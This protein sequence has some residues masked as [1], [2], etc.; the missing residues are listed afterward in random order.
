MAADGA[1]E[2]APVVIKH[3]HV[4]NYKSLADVSLLLDSPTVLV[5]RNGSGTSACVDVL[6]FVRDALRDG[7]DR[8]LTM[9]QGFEAVRRYSPTKPFQVEIDLEFVDS[10]RYQF[11]LASHGGDVIV[12]REEFAGKDAGG[13]LSFTVVDGQLRDATGTFSRLIPPL[14]ASEKHELLLYRLPIARRNELRAMAFY[15]VYPNTL[16]KP[17]P[18]ADASQLLDDCSNMASVLQKLSPARHEAVRSAVERVVPD[19]TDFSTATPPA[20]V[21]SAMPS[22]SRMERCVRWLWPRCCSHP[23][24]ATV[25][26]SSPRRNL[27]SDSTQVPSRNSGRSW[28]VQRSSGRS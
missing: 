7:L 26:G 16:R 14:L 19:V 18:P 5:G 3:L 8:A 1:R 11:V 17:Q 6:R 10:G 15:D 27:R 12:K 22:R 20:A 13:P 24:P 25:P 2:E 4:R 21:S 9:R 28:Q 23:R